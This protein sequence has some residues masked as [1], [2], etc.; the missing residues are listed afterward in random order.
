M[1]GVFRGI[2]NNADRSET[3]IIRSTGVAGVLLSLLLVNQSVFAQQSDPAVLTLDRIF[4][5][6]E[7]APESFGP[8]R[9]LED[10][11]GYTTVEPSTTQKGSRDIVR[12]EAGSGAR[13]VLVDAAVLKPTPQSAPLSIDDYSWS[14]NGRLLLLFTNA[15]QVWRQKTRGDYWVLDIASKKLRKLGGSDAKAASL[16]FAKFSPDNLNVGYVRDNNLY[17]E[18]LSTTRVTQL[19]KDGSRTIINGT[20]DWVYEEELGLRDGWGWSPNSRSIAFWQLDSEGVGSFDLINNTD[21][22]Y[23]KVTQIPYPKAGTT[24]SA[25]RVGVVGV[26]GGGPRWIE[27]PGDPRN[28][29]IAAMDWAG[30]S[31]EL[32]LQQLNRRQN[33]LNVMLGDIQSGKSHTILTEKDDAWVDM[34]VSDLHWLNGGKNFTWLS[35]RDGWRHLYVISRDGR[36]VRLV[37]PGAFDLT[38]V[39]TVDPDKNEIYYTASP[40]NATQRYLFRGKLDGNGVP[41]RISPASEPGT[42]SYKVSPHSDWAFHT[43]TTFST[44][45]RTEL[46][47]LP[48]HS[49]VRM[50]SGNEKLRE[51]VNALKRGPS[52]FFRVPVGGGVELDGWIIKPPDFDPSKRYPVL[53]HV[54]GEPASQTVL[55]R[56]GG[57]NELW[58]LMLAQQGYIVISVDNRGTPSP[59]GRQW[60]KVIYRQIGTLASQEQAAAATVIQE[61]PFVD[62]ARIAIWGWSGGGSMTLNQMFRRPDIYKVGMSVAPVSDLRLY[63]TIYQ[64][65]YMGLPQE[66]AED[67]KRG[68][69]ISFV[70]GLQGKLLV[71]HGSGDDN[72]HYQGTEVLINALVEANKPFTMMEYPNRRHDISSGKN[73]SRHLYGLLTRFLQ[74]NLPAGPGR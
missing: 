21:S 11:M 32:V 3:V 52:E 49:V 30:N 16:M 9:W 24:N 43:Y 38:S 65:R 70:D 69:P 56:W 67:Y 42:H 13:S 63:D 19:T 35:E 2:S 25:A 18:D 34:R 28:N 41:E 36:N 73:T 58:L 61:W 53:F 55:D 23:P 57:N 29:Y 17:V 44:P 1:A 10:G 37:T 12:Y 51:K 6:N 54:Y 48:N 8:A 14:S 31:N 7:F 39:E 22:L 64:E 72:V 15:Q 45:A 66:N 20:F 60:R 71:V 47:S 40:E 33:V 4:S 59:R 68:S 26:N 62:P 50:L 46:V 74:D 27:A 5:S